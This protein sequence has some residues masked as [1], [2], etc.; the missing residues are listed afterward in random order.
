MR[1]RER[2]IKEVEKEI[3]EAGKKK[4]KTVVLFLKKHLSPVFCQFLYWC[5]LPT[6]NFG[7]LLSFSS[8][9]FSQ[10]PK[11]LRASRGVVHATCGQ[12]CLLADRVTAKEKWR[13]SDGTHRL[14]FTTHQ[15][16]KTHVFHSEDNADNKGSYQ[17]RRFLSN[18]QLWHWWSQRAC[19][20]QCW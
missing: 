9:Q 7:F 8:M 17:W 13:E 3:R 4:K 12:S 2:E 18:K 5:L 1:E 16:Q 14:V 20:N 6:E 11:S 10:S 19:K 15:T